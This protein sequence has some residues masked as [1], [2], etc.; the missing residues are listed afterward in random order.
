[1]KTI[2]ETL[3]YLYSFINYEVDS[4]YD[5]GSI[6]YNVQRTIKLLNL[7]K[8]PENKIKI[9]HV[10]GT[11][12][13]GSICKI[14]SSLLISQNYTTGLFTSP[15]VNRVNERITVNDKEI[16]DEELIQITN[17]FPKL[18]DSFDPKNKPTTFELF[19][20]ISMLYFKIKNVEYAILETGM[21]GRFD[22]T[23]FSDPVLSII[24]PISYD[25]KDKLGESIEKIAEE[26]AG[27][28]KPM[29]PVII[30][31]QRFNIKDIL[32][33]KS[34]KVKSPYYETDKL[35]SFKIL[36]ASP[37]G[38]KFNLNIDELNFKDIFIS[39][40]GTHQVENTTTA[41]LAL[42]VLGLLP[43]EDTIKNTLN[44]IQFPTRLEL[45]ETKRRFLLDSAHNEDSARVVVDAIKIAYS[46]DKII[47]I[48]GIVKGKDFYGIIRNIS[49]ISNKVIIT[50]PITHKELDTNYLYKIS[51]QFAKDAI[52]IKDLKESIEY[53]ISKSTK[54]DIILITGSFYITSP[55]RKLILD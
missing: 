21:G 42:K 43:K 16:E 51:K 12:G 30:G 1:M 15:H 36:D 55:A 46:Y 38:M 13:K 5:Y 23:N 29:K 49:S 34:T 37:K 6:Y 9:I 26:K 18:I 22:S 10:A 52:L 45:I 20:A 7:L 25:H 53:A 19:T 54:K 40:T 4:S 8:N 14:I 3:D 41:L 31:Y 32:I 28:I 2:D 17:S 35:C 11:K 33:K 39:L 27:I 44:S 48:I 47:S 50:E 24:S